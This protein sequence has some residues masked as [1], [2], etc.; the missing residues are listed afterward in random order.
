MYFG[1]LH[2]KIPENCN[3][4]VLKESFLGPFPVLEHFPTIRNDRIFL[5]PRALKKT[6]ISMDLFILVDYTRKYTKIAV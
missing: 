5:F 1:W 4:K 3:K 6:Y 2:E